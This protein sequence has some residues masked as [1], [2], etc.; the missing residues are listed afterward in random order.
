M[1]SDREAVVFLHEKPI[2]T[3]ILLPGDRTMFA[4]DEAYINDQNRPTLSLSFKSSTGD[5]ITDIKPRQTRLPPFFSNLLPEGPMREFLAKRAGIKTEREFFLILALGH[6]LPGAVTV[7]KTGE[8]QAQP[9]KRQKIE[10][11]VGAPQNPLYFSLAGVQFKFSAIKK[12]AGG[13]TIPTHGDGGSWIVKLPS[14]TFDFVP[15][16]EFAMMKLAGQVGIQVP[17]VELIPIDRISGLP[18]E[19]SAM[20][21]N[22]LAVERFDRQP[23]GTAIHM[24]DF[25]QVFGQYPERKYERANYRNIAEII[26]AE[27]HQSDIAEFVRRL[28][29]NT[30]IGNGDMHLKNWSLI[31]PDRR[32]AKLA[33]AYDILSTIPY[34]K[35]ANTALNLVRTRDMTGLSL[36]RLSHFSV[37]AGLPKEVVL[38][39]AVDTVKAF[40]KIWKEGDVLNNLPIIKKAIHEHVQSIELV[41]S[42]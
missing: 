38:Q 33:P 4:F 5:L 2:G 11:S 35:E 22:A 36:E 13:L 21:G 23:D 39:T 42:V 8:L 17:K 16:N 9:L 30:L 10:N 20:K 40:L 1:T 34:I 29:F 31:Y 15:E 37:K 7:R 18:I 19:F 24:E 41:R 6:D 32:Q 14:A 28:V 26:R 25:A 3:F 27:C 12:A